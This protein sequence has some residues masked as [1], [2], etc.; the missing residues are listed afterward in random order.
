MR[1]LAIL[2]SLLV[3]STVLLSG[4]G[5]SNQSSTSPSAPGTASGQTSVTA[6]PYPPSSSTT[7]Q[8]AGAEIVISNNNYSVPPPVSPG[9]RISVVNNDE[10]AHSVTA[11]VNGAF[12]IRISG[13]G[14]TET[15]TA[16]TAPGTYPF[17]CKYHENMHGTLTVQ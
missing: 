11:D 3:L 14:G 13:G 16:P 17:H 2:F 5:G 1:P 10:A 8:P 4:C 12:D 6:T 9:A 15:L 7:A